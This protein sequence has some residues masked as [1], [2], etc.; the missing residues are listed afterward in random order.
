MMHDLIDVL[1]LLCNVCDWLLP[2]ISTTSLFKLI[3]GLITA[4]FIAV[5]MITGSQEHPDRKLSA[6]KDVAL[7]LFTVY[8]CIIG[9]VTDIWFLNVVRV[10]TLTLSLCISFHKEGEFI[11]CRRLSYT[12]SILTCFIMSFIKIQDLCII[13]TDTTL[14]ALFCQDCY[15][16]DASGE[17]NGV[18]FSEAKLFRVDWFGYD[19]LTKI[20]C[21]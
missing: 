11:S 4:M 21:V 2:V 9:S 15:S 18:K 20:K 8:T 6:Y 16:L 12:L 13:S 3:I 10:P 19:E 14:T 17:I 7:G 5:W 1:N